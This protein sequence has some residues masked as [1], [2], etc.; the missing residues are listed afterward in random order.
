MK[1]N[2][3]D[4]DVRKFSVE[5][6]V[7]NDKYRKGN[8]KL[9]EMMISQ[10]NNLIESTKHGDGPR[11]FI[12]DEDKIN[13]KLCSTNK[14]AY[15]LETGAGIDQFPNNDEIYS[16]NFF[17]SIKDY[18]DTKYVYEYYNVYTL[19][20][21]YGDLQ[22]VYDNY[23][24]H[25]YLPWDSGYEN[26]KEDNMIV[27]KEPESKENKEEIQEHITNMRFLMAWRDDDGD[28]TNHEV[29]EA[30]NRI[31]AH[32]IYED[33]HH[34]WHVGES[35]IIKRVPDNTPLGR[36]NGDCYPAYSDT[37]E[38]RG[39]MPLNILEHVTRFNTSSEFL[40]EGMPYILEIHDELGNVYKR[41][42]VVL[43][44]ILPTELRFRLWEKKPGQGL[45]ESH[46]LISPDDLKEKY[47]LYQIEENEI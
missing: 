7:A 21:M 27:N 8:L 47:N 1:E 31:Q 15:L 39:R 18:L 25:G 37:C 11:S 42:V 6:I 2:K 19:M 3:K 34:K 13:K 28:L 38:K 23:N 29:V 22:C 45:S 40:K 12:I 14:L 4:D 16:M 46:W 33:S 10:I 43:Y 5:N 32:R 44:E 17:E 26:D 35:V 36:C 30:K 20:E 41:R 9:L 24:K